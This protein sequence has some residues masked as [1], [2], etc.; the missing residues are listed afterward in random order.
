MRSLFRYIIIILTSLVFNHL[1][2][3]ESTI[4]NVG[5][6]TQSVSLLSLV[7]L[8]FDSTAC[9]DI[10]AEL[11]EQSLV[12]F[13]Y[14]ES[15]IPQDL[16]LSVHL[17][18][19]TALDAL[20]Y[21]IDQMDVDFM[22]S[23]GHQVI[24]IPK[25]PVEENKSYTI[26]GYI[27]DKATGEA[28][29][30]TNIFVEG[31]RVGCSSNKYGFYSITLPNGVY[32]LNV[33]F[34]GYKTQRI[35]LNLIQNIRQDIELEETPIHGQAVSITAELVD[36]HV[37]STQMGTVQLSPQKFKDMPI[38]LGEQDLFKTIHLL[39]GVMQSRE[40]DA[41]FYVRGGSSDQNLVLLDE[42]PVYNAYHLVGFFS[43]FNTD[44][45][46]DFKL[47]KGTAPAK[48]GGRLSSV[49]D[50]Q[51]NE[52][53]VKEWGGNAGLGLI[54]SRFML[55]GPF[56][57]DKG[58][59]L[60]TG[61]RTYADML[62]RLS[63]VED[64]S[65]QTLYFYDL[66]IK[67]NYEISQKDHLY[68]SGYLGNDV[69]GA[70]NTVDINWGNRT[71]T[72]RWNHLFNERLFSNTSLIFSKFNYTMSVKE[73]DEDDPDIEIA[74]DIHDVTLKQDFQYFHST[75]HTF[76]FGAQ[77]IYHTFLPGAISIAEDDPVDVLI[78]KRNAHE[79]AIY[80]SH[81]WRMLPRLTLNYGL[82]YSLFDVTGVGDTWTFDEND[83]VPQ[84]D[85][86]E[87]EHKQYYGLEPRF[88]ANIR[89]TESSALKIGYSRNYQNIHL[90]SNSTSGT[91]LDIWQPSSTRIRPQRADQIS[92]GYFKNME[93]RGLEFSTEFYYKDMRNQL[94]FK[95]G[96][97]ILWST[98]F[99]TDLAMGR[100]WAY[101]AEFF[102][103]KHVGRVTGWLSYTLSR[104]ERQFDE[105]NNGLAFPVRYDRT[106]D[107]SCVFI[108]R[109][110]PKW[111]FS[112][113]WVY[114]TGDAVTIPYGK[115]YIDDQSV[116]AISAR[117]GYR[118]PSYHRLDL[119]VTLNTRKSGSW[120]FALYNAYG[121][122]NP[123]GYIFRDKDNQPLQKEAV[124]ISLFSFLPS[125]TY[126][127]EF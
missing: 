74:S 11:E 60:I 89:L 101:G 63:S 64:I 36:N 26:S 56:V 90:L 70:A 23:D 97:N 95:N 24:L 102:L 35:P 117:N 127:F 33:R 54:F 49:L 85:L 115:Y 83:D 124:M 62:M 39:P 1:V 20:Q 82:R 4:P 125:V 12:R 28:M 112:A 30:G 96:A 2:A 68:I 73:E 81:E 14:S 67:A 51:M 29:I 10:L 16:R 52:G 6:D 103:K 93:D 99:E 21:L 9:R 37:Q 66:S 76:D 79:G 44:A 5:Q 106:H 110:N 27:S 91:P 42:A 120:I 94:D 72:I 114:H 119:S 61:R 13:N 41:G 118:F 104:A 47:I 25:R 59:I 116:T 78:G 3:K 19:V 98:F 108:Y 22:I 71:G 121:R 75:Q 18:N 40:A 126:N 113:N 65:Q 38:L 31:L 8:N 55:Q 80:I 92:F 123:Y 32:V 77:Y 100:G 34:I 48:Y 107:I 45:I 69:F 105:I 86:H 109:Y 88:A 50:I 7:S 17:N 53:N 46:R 15:L 122:K 58:S 111:T 57:Y 84:V 87:D 43:V